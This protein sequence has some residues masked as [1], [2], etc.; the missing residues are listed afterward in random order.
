MFNL[1]PAS[2]PECI[3]VTLANIPLHKP[4]VSLPEAYFGSIPK[5]ILF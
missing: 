4:S 1:D 3:N 2:K 5:I